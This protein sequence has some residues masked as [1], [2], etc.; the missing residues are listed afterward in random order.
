MSFVE[1]VADF[2]N[3][4]PRAAIV[5]VAFIVIMGIFA[6]W[7]YMSGKSAEKEVSTAADVPVKTEPT[8]EPKETAPLIPKEVPVA[9]L[10]TTVVNPVVDDIPGELE[11]YG[12]D[13]DSEML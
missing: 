13:S 5:A 7:K 9:P 8:P 4:V 3:S 12:S 1:K 10:M 6:I 11:P 2:I